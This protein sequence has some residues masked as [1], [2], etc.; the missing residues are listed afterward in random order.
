MKHMLKDKAEEEH[1]LR[2][3]KDKDDLGH[4]SRLHK[5][6]ADE[7]HADAEEDSEARLHLHQCHIHNKQSHQNN[8]HDRQSLR[9]R[10]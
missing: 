10:Q 8:V 1:D 9:L 4:D 2:L 3:H 5:R 7:D 6:K